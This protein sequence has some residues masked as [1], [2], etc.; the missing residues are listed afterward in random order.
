M[1]K[2]KKAL[3]KNSFQRKEHSRGVE[4]SGGILVRTLRGE[5]TGKR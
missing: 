2:R 3:G 5:V 1:T 4:E